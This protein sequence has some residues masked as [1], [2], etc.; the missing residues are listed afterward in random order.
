MCLTSFPET[1]LTG[2]PSDRD[3]SDCLMILVRASNEQNVANSF[4]VPCWEA[5]ESAAHTPMTHSLPRHDPPKRR[6]SV[7]PALCP[8]LPLPQRLSSQHHPRP[9]GGL[10]PP[11]Q[12]VH[13]HSSFVVFVSFW[14]KHSMNKHAQRARP[15]SDPPMHPGQ[16][17]QVW[18]LLPRM[19]N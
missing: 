15:L 16:R 14:R 10:D 12:F 1:V 9:E 19:A 8:L 2:S 6:R 7:P 17:W 5:A 11:K 3:H 4:R 18:G 13:G